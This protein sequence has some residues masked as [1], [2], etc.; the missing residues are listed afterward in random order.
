M[1]TAGPIWG[2]GGTKEEDGGGEQFFV[3][4]VGQEGWGVPGMGEGN[5]VLRDFPYQIPQG[6]LTQSRLETFGLE[7]RFALLS[8]YL[9]A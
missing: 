9:Y 1:L 3:W 4:G 6:I 2:R 7:I 8:I 5:F